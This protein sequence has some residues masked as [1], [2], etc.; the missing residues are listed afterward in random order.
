M[1][2]PTASAHIHVGAPPPGYKEERDTHSVHDFSSSSSL[3]IPE[4]PVAKMIQGLWRRKKHSLHVPQRLVQVQ[5]LRGCSFIGLSSFK[6][7]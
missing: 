3:F 4:N 5:G 2:A 7:L 6:S 1:N